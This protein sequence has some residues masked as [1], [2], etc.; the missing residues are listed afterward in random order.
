[1]RNIEYKKYIKS[2]DW[3][4]IRKKFILEKGGK[5]ADCGALKDLHVHHLHYRTIGRERSD[6]V[7]ILC[8]DCHEYRHLIA[9]VNEELEQEILYIQRNKDDPDLMQEYFKRK[10]QQE[11]DDLKNLYESGQHYLL[12]R[13]LM[14]MFLFEEDKDEEYCDEGAR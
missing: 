4:S 9:E 11:A 13:Y 1:M 10:D 8:A 6:D 14:K 3:Q 5:C 7:E 2:A 12:N